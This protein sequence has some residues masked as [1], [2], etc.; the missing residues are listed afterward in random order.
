MELVLG[1][2]L[3]G[4]RKGLR[5]RLGSSCA[6]TALAPVILWASSRFLLSPSAAQEH[7]AQIS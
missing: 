7:K 2:S 4:L 6:T 5:K 3:I 1:N